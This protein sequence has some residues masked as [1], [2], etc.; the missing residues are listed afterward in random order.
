MLARRRQPL[1]GA[2]GEPGR[3]EP[4]SSSTL[5]RVTDQSDGEILNRGYAYWS[6]AWVHPSGAVFLFAGNAD[7]RPRFCRVDPDG[8][9]ARMGPMLGYAGTSEG[10]YWDRDGFIY[11]C[12]GP[13]LRRV[14][15]FTG[16]DS[17]VLD[18]SETHPGCDLW[19]AHSSDDG[20]T[21]SATVRR[22]VD[23]G[24]YPKLGTVVQ[25]GPIQRFIEAVGLLD[26]SHISAD[27]SILIIEESDGNRILDVLAV[28]N[29]IESERGISNFEGA[30]SHID[31]GPDYAAG[32]DDQAGACV[33]LDLRTMERTKLFDTRQM[34]HV[35]VRAGRCLL[36]DTTQLALVALDGSGVTPLIDHGMTGE[37][38]DY[39]VFGNLSP[40]GS[41]AAFISNKAGRNDLYL[42]RL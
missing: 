14:S 36:T 18:I 30:L 10:W 8:T 1:S 39:Q 41:V 19:Q 17:V 11:L 32:E 31:C 7:G 38:Y 27:G 35:S 4:R 6:Q 9:V 13:R 23:I 22:I 42:L 5:I 37:G 34:G 28:L 26:E 24:A 20:Q 29:G 15:P 40:D 16:A 3:V 33:K 21:H 25:R 12:D 2:G